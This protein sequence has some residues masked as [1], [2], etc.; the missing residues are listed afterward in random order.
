[1][2]DI[3]DMTSIVAVDRPDEEANM[4][5][6]NPAARLQQVIDHVEAFQRQFVSEGAG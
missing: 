6:L 2:T 5:E 1:M 4:L 3:C